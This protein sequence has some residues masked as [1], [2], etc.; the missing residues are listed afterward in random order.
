MQVFEDAN[1]ADV[2]TTSK[3]A[4][5]KFVRVELKIK[6]LTVREKPRDVNIPV[7]NEGWWV[8]GK[9]KFFMPGD[10]RFAFRAIDF[11]LVE[12]TS[13]LNQ[14]PAVTLQQ[15]VITR[16]GAE[17]PIMYPERASAETFLCVK[18]VHR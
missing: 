6:D 7:A 1:A 12:G 9:L 15:V 4:A 18:F 8:F 13:P 10:W 2:C 11:R 5:G 14:A 16:E 17:K 3:V